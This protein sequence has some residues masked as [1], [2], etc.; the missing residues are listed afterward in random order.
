[1]PRHIPRILP[2]V[3]AHPFNQRKT[4]PM[5]TQQAQLEHHQ[6]SEML[7]FTIGGEEYGI[8]IRN[9]QEIRGYESVVTQAPEF[10]KG[11]I[12]LHGKIVPV[13]DM[14]IKFKFGEVKFDDTAVVIVLNVENRMVGMV[15]DSVTE[16]I[17]LNPEQIEPA[18]EFGNKLGRA[19]A[20]WQAH[21]HAG[22]HREIDG[23][24]QYCAA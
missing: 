21:D 11:A 17:A 22:A 23:R 13:V 2:L 1:M 3:S 4:D 8:D 19:W 18:P 14:R 9:V 6:N 5:Q 16:V 7:T 20:Q 10:I 12:N 24:M 15:V